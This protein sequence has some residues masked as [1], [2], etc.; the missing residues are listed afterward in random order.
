MQ[1]KIDMLT[2]QYKK[3]KMSEG[4]SIIYMHTPFTSIMIELE[5]VI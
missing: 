3:L 2:T 1:A 4:E 5:C